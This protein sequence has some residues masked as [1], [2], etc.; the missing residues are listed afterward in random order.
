[1]PTPTGVGDIQ[2]FLGLVT[3]VSKFVENM[4]ERTAPL[5]ALL[6][7]MQYLRG[8]KYTMMRLMILKVYLH[9]VRVS[10]FLMQMFLALSL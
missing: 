6:K 3:Y 8:T 4:S 2:R 7:K 5:R 10:S 9:K 1:M